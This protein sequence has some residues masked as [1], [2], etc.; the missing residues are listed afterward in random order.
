MSRRT[1]D[2][3][4]PLVYVLA[5]IVAI[6]IGDTGGVGGVATIGAVCVAAYFGALRQN[7]KAGRS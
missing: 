5:V 2:I 7:I 3:L 6:V 4:V 1:F